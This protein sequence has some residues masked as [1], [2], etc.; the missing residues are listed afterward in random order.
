MNEAG[1]SEHE[2]FNKAKLITKKFETSYQKKNT[3]KL[4]DN[5]NAKI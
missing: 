3:F 1:L 4:I 5:I 2:R